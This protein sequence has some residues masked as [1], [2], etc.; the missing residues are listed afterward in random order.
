[1]I[2]TYLGHQFFKIQQGDL[3]IAIDPPA[4]SSQ[5]K[6]SKFGADIVLS[7]LKHEDF[8]GYDEMG[9]G[10]RVPFVAYGPGEYEVKGI[11][12][13]GLAGTSSYKTHGK[14]AVKKD[15]SITERI[16][17]IYTLTVDNIRLCFLGAQDSTPLSAETKESLEDIDVLFVP[18]SGDGVLD[19]TQAYKLA[20]SLEPKLIIPCHFD[21]ENEETFLRTFLKEGG[22]KTF[23]PVDKLTI[24][25]KDL[26][27]KDGEIVVLSSQL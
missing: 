24:K 8:D 12:I 16:N 4:K 1:M 5:Y 25:R 26:D 18:I 2:I 17:T 15:E 3:T 10:D 14:S 22:V 19:A 6:S 21:M 7:S 13:K 20:V 11:F 9:Y 27:G 23:E